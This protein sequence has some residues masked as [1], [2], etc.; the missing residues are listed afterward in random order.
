M[1]LLSYKNSTIN[2]INSN[3]ISENLNLHIIFILISKR[4]MSNDFLQNYFASDKIF[5]SFLNLLRNTSS[6]FLFNHC[7]IG[8]AIFKNMK[9][10][11][12]IGIRLIIDK[13]ECKI[14][15]NGNEEKM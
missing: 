13:Y 12:N 11:T 6:F 1:H 15:T 4:K 14:L 8:I 3:R 7:A 2:K 10:P 5:R 9:E